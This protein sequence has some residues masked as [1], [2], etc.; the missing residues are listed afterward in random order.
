LAAT[1]RSEAGLERETLSSCL[2][3]HKW[4]TVPDDCEEKGNERFRLEH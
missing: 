3:T 2:D 1:S 4:N